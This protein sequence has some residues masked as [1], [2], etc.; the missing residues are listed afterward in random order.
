MYMKKKSIKKKSELTELLNVGPRSAERIE[1]VGIKTIDQFMSH[2]PE[3]IYEKMNKKY[4]TVF[5]P[6][7][8]YVMRA[9]QFY[10][11]NQDK[12]EHARMWWLFKEVK[13]KI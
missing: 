10:E 11:R 3:E 2:T 4:K 7:F 1:A 8:L 5:H 12:R 13:K 6:A 9:A